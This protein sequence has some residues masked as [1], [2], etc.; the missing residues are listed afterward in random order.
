M[1]I[2]MPCIGIC[3][4]GARAISHAFFNFNVFIS[5]SVGTFLDVDCAFFDSV[6][7][8]ENPGGSGMLEAFL[9]FGRGPSFSWTAHLGGG[10]AVIFLLR[11][12]SQDSFSGLFR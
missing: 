2:M 4:A 5:T 8:T 11:I 9:D 1:Y 3:F 7:D 10:G 6:L 12:A